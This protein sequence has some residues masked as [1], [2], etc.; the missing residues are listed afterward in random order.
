M[1]MRAL[2]FGEMLDEIFR[3]Y[4]RNFGLLVLLSLAPV[5]PTLLLEIG[6]GQASQ[7][8]ILGSLIATL[9]NPA[10]TPGIPVPQ[11]NVALLL[12]TYAVTVALV[13]F[14]TGLVPRAGIDLA[15]GQP[16]DFR[17]AVVG[18]LRRYWGLLAVVVLYALVALL[19]VTCILLPLAVWILVRWTVAVPVLLAEGAGPIAALAR[20]W[21]LTRGSWW[22]TL[23]I[24]VV[25]LLIQ[26]VAS[27]LLS[28]FGLPVAVLV[29]FVPEIVRGTIIVGTSTLGAAVVTPIWQLCFVLIYFD[30]RVRKEHLDLWQL[31]DLAGAAA[32]GHSYDGLPA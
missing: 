21:Q 20:S 13:P 7:F 1:R 25:V 6:S 32:R 22:R 10:A 31:A 24:L 27:S 29:P 11:V 16:T 3:F 2:G 19:A 15:L 5:L 14:S 26:Y 9:G 28:L 30:L 4:R 12:A 17:S 23:G 8:G 18:T